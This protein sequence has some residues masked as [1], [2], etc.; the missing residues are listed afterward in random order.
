MLEAPQRVI[1]NNLEISIWV[2]TDAEAAARTAANLTRSAI[3]E[4]LAA[5]PSCALALTGGS[6][7]VRTYQILA[8]MDLPWDAIH[9]FQTDQRHLSGHVPSAWDAIR[10][11]LL[12]PASIPARNR[13]PIAFADEDA[14][15]CA[16]EYS[17]T[18][19]RVCH[20]AT[21]D[22]AILSLGEGG[23]TASLF[24]GDPVLKSTSRVGV[25]Q[26]HNGSARV[27]LT[28]LTLADVQTRIMVA[29]GDGKATEVRHMLHGN[30]SSPSR[31]VLARGGVLVTDKRAFSA[32]PG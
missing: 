32:T 6:S 3:V 16:R 7:P 24:P 23:H 1:D 12:D 18:L 17:H 2:A 8:T 9:F 30:V 10:T 19:A 15:K 27:T 29:T 26:T 11:N 25:T 4:T 31:Q 13:H 21:P 5:R 20:R 22:I 28:P 14:A